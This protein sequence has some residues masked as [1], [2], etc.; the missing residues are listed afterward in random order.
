[1]ITSPEKEKALIS[2]TEGE[3]QLLHYFWGPGGEEGEEEEEEEEFFMFN[4]TLEGPRA[5]AVKSGRVIQEGE[6]GGGKRGE[7]GCV[8]K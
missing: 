2:T 5:P 1:M 4:D 8:W 7:E 6:V 3:D